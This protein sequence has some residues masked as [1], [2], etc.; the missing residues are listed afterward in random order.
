MAKVTTEVFGGSLVLL[1]LLLLHLPPARKLGR[2]FKRWRLP[3]RIPSALNR[4]SLILEHRILQGPSIP[5]PTALSSG[6]S[7][8][9]LRVVPVLRGLD[10]PLPPSWRTPRRAS[11]KDRTETSRLRKN[12]LDVTVRSIVLLVRPVAWTEFPCFLPFSR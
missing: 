1:R 3:S 4:E 5:S 11:V 7:A 6:S 9:G 12:I 10:P 8:R 2:G